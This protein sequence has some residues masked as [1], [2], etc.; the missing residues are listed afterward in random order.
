[1]KLLKMVFLIGA[2]CAANSAHA[3][4]IHGEAG[5]KWTNFGVSFGANEPGFTFSG[6]WAHN[7]NDGDVASLGMGWNIPLVRYS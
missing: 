3:V 4:S 5:A 1:M 2:V 7:D 6:N